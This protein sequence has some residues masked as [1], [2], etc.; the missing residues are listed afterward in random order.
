MEKFNYLAKAKGCDLICLDNLS[1]VVAG[2]DEGKGGERKDIDM[3]MSE[4]AAFVTMTG[5]SVIIVVHLKRSNRRM[6]TKPNPETDPFNRG[7]VVSL[8]DMRGSGGLEQ[9]CFNI[10]ALEGDQYGPVEGLRWLRNLKSRERGVIGKA[11]DLMYHKSTG[12]L[13]PYTEVF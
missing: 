5:V 1:L 13:L 10:W 8:D 4:L 6:G 7:G 3:L 11:D 12:R 9:M 2:Q